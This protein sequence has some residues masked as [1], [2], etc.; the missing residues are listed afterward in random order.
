MTFLKVKFF[1]TLI[2]I[3]LQNPESSHPPN[4]TLLHGRKRCGAHPRCSRDG[5]V[6]DTVWAPQRIVSDC[7]S[8]E[9][10]LVI[11]TTSPALVE[12]KNTMPQSDPAVSA[13]AHKVVGSDFDALLGTEL[14][15]VSLRLA[16]AIFKWL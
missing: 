10:A 5:M 7:H 15:P 3:S 1:D 8:Y 11:Y 13:A 6:F 4:A 14:Q 2:V 9:E 16:Y 12:R